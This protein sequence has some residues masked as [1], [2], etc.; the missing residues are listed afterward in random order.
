[1]FEIDVRDKL[2]A[3][4]LALDSQYGVGAYKIDFA[5]RH[6]EQPGKHV[7]AIEA[8]GAAYHSGQT[9]RDRDRLRQTLLESRGWVFCRIW[10]TDWFNDADA[11][12]TRVL[13]AYERAL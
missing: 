11:E 2:V 6:P 1:P 3:A 5:V 10:S 12:I 4:G 8:D 7:L 9:A 13:Q